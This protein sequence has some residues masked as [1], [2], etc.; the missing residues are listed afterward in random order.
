MFILTRVIC[1]EMIRRRH[2]SKKMKTSDITRACTVASLQK[3]LIS[4]LRLHAV[5]FSA[6]KAGAAVSAIQT[7]ITVIIPTRGIKLGE[8]SKIIE[9]VITNT[10]YTIR[11]INNCNFGT[12]MSPKAL[13]IVKYTAEQRLF[14]FLTLETDTSRTFFILRVSKPALLKACAT[15]Q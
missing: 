8:K 6:L 7:F 1:R 5:R 12:V 15:N 9:V 11:R 3:D 10:T 4:W 14:A 13:K 2:S